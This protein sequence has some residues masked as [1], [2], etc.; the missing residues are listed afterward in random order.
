MRKQLLL[1][2]LKKHKIN[3]VRSVL[4]LSQFNLENIDIGLITL[5]I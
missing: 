1:S 5:K 4:M 2:I 3:K